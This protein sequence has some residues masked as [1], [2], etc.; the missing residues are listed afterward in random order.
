[1]RLS[2]LLAAM[3]AATASIGVS[4]PTRG[5]TIQSL[6]DAPQQNSSDVKT[7][8][9]AVPETIAVQAKPTTASVLDSSGNQVAVPTKTVLDAVAHGGNPQDRAASLVQSV[10]TT[11]SGS[12]SSPTQVAVPTKPTKL[13]VPVDSSAAELPSFTPKPPLSPDSMEG[14]AQLTPPNGIDQPSQLPEPN[15]LEPPSTQPPLSIHSIEGMAQLTPP[16]RID[17]LSQL[18][19]ATQLEPPSTQPP[20]SIHSI[21][22]S[23]QLTP[24]N[25][26]DQLSQLPEPNQLEPPST[27]PPSD[28]SEVRVLVAEV[29]ITGAPPQLEEEIYRVIKTRPGRATTRSQLQEDVNAI[30]ATGFFSSVDVQPEDTPLGVRISFIVRANP[31]LRQVAVKT[32]PPGEGQRIVNQEKI[33]EIFGEQYGSILNLRDL[34]EGIKQLNDWYKKEGYDLAQVIDAEQVSPDGTVTLVVAEGVIEAVKVRFLDEDG[35]PIVDENGNPIPPMTDQEEPVGGNT[36]PFI[37]TREVELKSGTVF[38]RKKAQRDLQRVFG[39]GIF[40]DVR[41]SFE[42]GTDPRQV[43]IVVDVIEKSSGSIA[44]GAGLSSASGFF[45]T[46]SYQQQNLGGNNQTLGG[47]FQLGTRELLFDLS[48]TDPWIAGDPFRTS[49]TVNAFRRR[50]ISLVF[51]GG[52]GENNIKVPNDDDDGDRPRIVRT[53]GGVTFRRPLSQ[54]VFKR[55]E[56]TAS[57]GLK[58][59]H[60]A[61][62]DSDG[63][64]RPESTDGELLS[65]SDSGEDDLTTVQLGAVRDLR[66]S[67]TQ[68][69]KGSLLRLGMEQS[70]PI[71]SGSI[72]MNRLR[73]SYSFYIPVEF[74]NFT[75]GP[76][77]LA[78]NIQGGT[79]LGDLPPYEA[80]IIGGSNSVRGFAEGD[81]ASGR[82]YLQA[83]AEYRFP[84]FSV[85]GGALFVD[86]GTD[87]GSAGAV[88]GEPGEQRDLPGTGLGYGLGVRV[89]SPLGPIRVD[90]GL[91]T[92]GDSRLHFGIGEKF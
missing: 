81:L 88:P 58:Y 14:S 47:E 67:T 51:N 40:D 24:P 83:T 5:Q 78:F 43:V 89:Q 80:F 34:Q 46:V 87:L 66:N 61:I 63:D 55:S 35:N 27:E 36:R 57:L 6:P 52:S 33:N 7:A 8:L 12:N 26:I 11:L 41:F 91:N 76:Q 21:E 59:Q 19:E 85:I 45:G 17:Q 30:F 13:V 20:L 60:V 38:N 28:S 84:I 92:E 32:E 18:P 74:T 39:L 56:W 9:Q 77:A 53:G 50:S 90:F 49:Y 1:M 29:L 65:F 22:G 3:I 64:V 31:V 73:G 70:I 23:A 42:P 62:E 86:A 2:P 16:N 69:T 82:S 25:R 75:E 15:Q 68:P 54:D 4:K 71:G 44:A 48:F 79:I 72:L 10:P 37:I